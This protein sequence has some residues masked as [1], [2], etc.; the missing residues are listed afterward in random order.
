MPE[1]VKRGTS[2]WTE[3]PDGSWL[4]WSE[5]E[6]QWEVSDFP[7]P[8]PEDPSP[9]PT[10]PST[11]SG[12]PLQAFATAAKIVLGILI[13]LDV[14]AVLSDVAQVEL[15]SALVDGDFSRLDEAESSDARQA[16]IGG[17]QLLGII[18]GAIFFIR[19]MHRAYWNVS[20][21]G[22]QG[23]PARPGWAIGA[24][25]VPIL[26][27]FRPKQM[28][29]ATW[30]ASDPSLQQ[31]IGETWRSGPVPATIHWWWAMWLISGFMGWISLRGMS[32][33]NT[34][35]QILAFSWMILVSDTC[36]VAAGILAYRTV[37]LISAR[38]A[39][40]LGTSRRVHQE[41]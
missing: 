18:V 32:A 23:L 24:W 27:L 19:W 37:N 20:E 8:P 22:A 40:I 1:P 33:A 21:F 3:R 41:M 14:I 6:E 11:R 2:W 30:K 31:P 15:V 39:A 34:P 9:L 38:Q 28:I 16:G 7:P 13:G 10:A 26:N 25:F 12:A 36:A 17:L 4:R 35:D 29:D 5:R